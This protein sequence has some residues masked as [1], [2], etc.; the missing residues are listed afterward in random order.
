MSYTV[1]DLKKMIKSMNDDDKIAFTYYTIDDI[2]NLALNFQDE[3]LSEKQIDE[4]LALIEKWGATGY[5]T[6][7]DAIFE[8][9]NK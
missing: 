4:V 9:V 3:K 5:E 7:T 2:Q 6:V 8:V 1:A